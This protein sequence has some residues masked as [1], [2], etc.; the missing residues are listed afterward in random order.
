MKSWFDQIPITL[1]ACKLD[2]KKLF[3]IIPTPK[4]SLNIRIKQY[5]KDF[6]DYFAWRL[7]FEIFPGTTY[8][9]KIEKFD[10]YLL[11]ENKL[12][13]RIAKAIS[14][15]RN[16]FLKNKDYRAI[17]IFRLFVFYFAELYKV[18]KK[19]RLVKE[20]RR[21]SGA[22]R[23]S[24]MDIGILINC[25]IVNI[26]KIPDKGKT[27]R[28]IKKDG[29]DYHSHYLLNDHLSSQQPKIWREEYESNL[30]KH[31][32]KTNPKSNKISA[33]NFFN[34]CYVKDETKIIAMFENNLIDHIGKNLDNI[35]DTEEKI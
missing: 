17:I 9:D 4:K 30:R 35:G 14:E 10:N 20:K 19:I 31:L 1:D 34:L 22:P 32:K 29:Y 2:F 16:E 28:L 3:K 15:L 27:G 24:R 13:K 21:F 11:P 26:L 5:K 12:I 8:L 25:I 33:D 7:R 23:Q 18:K 6:L